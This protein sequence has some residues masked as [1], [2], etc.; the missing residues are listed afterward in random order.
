MMR[1]KN[2]YILKLITKKEWKNNNHPSITYLQG[3]LYTISR[4]VISHSEWRYP[5]HWYSTAQP[6]TFTHQ[7]QD[8]FS[9]AERK[10]FFQSFP[11]ENTLREYLCGDIVIFYSNAWRFHPLRMQGRITKHISSPFIPREPSFVLWSNTLL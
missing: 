5:T 3:V 10:V 7:S 2:E 4:P 9:E 8:S 6:P 1:I 11:F